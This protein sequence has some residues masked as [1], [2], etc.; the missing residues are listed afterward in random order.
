M[1]QPPAGREV[2]FLGLGGNMSD[3]IYYLN[4]AVRFLDA[5]PEVEIDDISSVYQT[6]PVGPSED[7]F[8]NVA[9]RVLTRLSPLRLLRACQQVEDLLGRVRTVRWGPRTIDVDVLL[10]GDRVITTS[11]LTVPHPELTG[12]AFAMVPLLEVAT[13]WQL[14]DGRSLASVIADL[15]PIEGVQAIGRQVSLE[16]LPDGPPEGSQA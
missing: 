3:R 12:R 5:D 10:Y 8:Y 6:E 11:T 13:G 16:D 2:A 15:A 9:V 14:P 1:R 7:P 4:R